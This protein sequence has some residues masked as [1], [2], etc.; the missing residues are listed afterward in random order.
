MRSISPHRE[1]VA[2]YHI[3]DYF[4]MLNDIFGL[5]NFQQL[6]E[7]DFENDHEY[8]ALKTEEFNMNAIK[9]TL[10]VRCVEKDFLTTCAGFNM[11]P[12]HVLANLTCSICPEQILNDN[13]QTT[14]SNL[15]SK[16]AWYLKLNANK[17]NILY[18]NLLNVYFK[19]S[20]LY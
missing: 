11:L 7:T 16:L 6:F 12:N 10:P 1:V 19:L 8:K 18:E 4:N 9:N 17:N 2:M 3:K 20:N 5:I 15:I 14:I 13:I